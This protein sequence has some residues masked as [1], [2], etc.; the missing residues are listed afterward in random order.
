[1]KAATVPTVVF[2]SDIEVVRTMVGGK[3]VHGVGIP[4]VDC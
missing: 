1:M 2:L 3:M 4:N